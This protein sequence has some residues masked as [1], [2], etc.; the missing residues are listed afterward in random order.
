MFSIYTSLYHIEKHSFPWRP[1]L[2]N[3]VSFVGPE[4]EVVVAV[5]KSEDNTLEIIKEFAAQNPTVKIVETNYEYSDIT[6]DGKIRDAALQATTKP[7]KI[8]MDADEIIPLSNKAK[9]VE[10]ANNL[11]NSKAVCFMIPSVDVYG[12]MDKIRA[13]HPIGVKFR[14]HKEGFKRGVWKNAW[15]ADKIN[16]SLSDSCELLDQFDELIQGTHI[17]NQMDLHPLFCAN[18]ANFPYVLHLGYLS[19]EH[20]LNINNK[21]WKSHWELRSGRPENVITSKEV[22]D[23]E[24]VISHNLPIT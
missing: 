9:W 21:L 23:S 6:M 13:N 1:S 5:N 24:I 15:R 2:E 18:L 19:F 11:L 17:V 7:V 10:Y 14:M 22:L 12:S 8:Q 3:F 20:R 4:G 16:T